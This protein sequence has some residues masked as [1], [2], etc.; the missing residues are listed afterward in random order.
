MNSSSI[1]STG[2]PQQHRPI[3][4][5]DG[6]KLKDVHEC[7][8]DIAD[9]I[10]T[11]H[12]GVIADKEL[13]DFLM[14]QDILRDPAKYSVDEEKIITEYKAHLENRPMIQKEAYHSYNEVVDEMKALQAKHPDLCKMESMGKTAE[15]REIWA[16]KV[17]KGAGGDT[18]SKPGI[19][20]TGLTHAREPMG[21]EVCTYLMKKMADGYEGDPRIKGRVDSAEIWFMPVVNP[22]GLEYAR[23]ENSYWRKNRNPFDGKG[24]EANFEGNIAGVENKGG[25]VGVDLNRNFDDGNPAHAEMYRPKGDTPGS[26]YD[27][28]GASDDPDDDTYRGKSG[29]SEKEIQAVLNLDLGHKNIKG[30]IDFHSY[31]NLILYPWGHNYDPVENVDT[32]KDLGSKMN[33]AMGN[34][35]RLMQSADLYPA[36]GSS[37]NLHHANKRLNFTIEI[38]RSFYPDAKEIEPTCKKLYESCSTF[39]DYVI[40]HKDQ[41]PWPDPKT[42]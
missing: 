14:K 31:G 12:N 1:S 16:M 10:D 24:A 32:Y 15:G 13:R 35:F 9:T 39:M 25:P 42:A 36:T 3:K 37:E 6:E 29:G 27:D 18:S 17:S 4:F 28:E 22:D 8:L 11:D 26:T 30:V 33:S 40:E 38:G 7:K 5:V 19:L 41:I 20:F 23:T 34:S 2:G 21:M